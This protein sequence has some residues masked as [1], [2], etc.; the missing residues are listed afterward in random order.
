M[1]MGRGTIIGLSVSATILLMAVLMFVK[2]KDPMLLVLAVVLGLIV[3]A[4]ILVVT[5][6]RRGIPVRVV[7]EPPAK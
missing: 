7:G 6:L 1:S 3:W 4:I 2:T 5:L